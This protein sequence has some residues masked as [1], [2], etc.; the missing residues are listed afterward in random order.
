MLICIILKNNFIYLLRVFT[1]V[2]VLSLAAASGVG[3]VVALLLLGST[4]SRRAAHRPNSCG[5]RALEHTG[6]VVGRMGFVAQWH[7]ESS[8]TREQICVPC[9][10]R[11]IPIHCTT[12]EVPS[13]SFFKI[14]HIS[15]TI[16]Y[17]SFSDLRHLV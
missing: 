15:D 9:I 2:C 7:V 11:Q 17:S 16:C 6:S 1:A 14:P 3:S 13:V 10:G 12:R 5:S 4:G 8:Q